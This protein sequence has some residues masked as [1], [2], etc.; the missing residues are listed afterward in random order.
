MG[1]SAAS[2]RGVQRE[3]SG[4]YFLWV[5]YYDPHLEHQAPAAFAER[6]PES[7]YDAEVAYVDRELGRLVAAFRRHAGEG[8]ALVV[9]TH[10]LVCHSLVQRIL[11]LDAE[12]GGPMGFGNTAV[13]AA[14]EPEIP[15]ERD[16]SGGAS[17]HDP[18]GGVGGGVVDHD[19]FAGAGRGELI[20]DLE[21]AVRWADTCSLS[22][23]D[24]PAYHDFYLYQT[25][26]ATRFAQSRR[27]GDRSQRI[28]TYNFPENRLTDHRINL[29]LYKLDQ[30]IAGN[31]QPVS[32]ALIDH[33]REQL[34]SSIESEN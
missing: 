23:D 24:D 10:G 6:F 12:E 4:P 2:P 32:D 30:I 25:L 21:T 34:R 3:R 14:D 7:P 11:T 29:T 9:V 13:T 27:S 1:S 22:F 26:L 16:Q 33:D 28:R 5:H 20:G 17:A 15:V 18:S 8:G 31:L 19:D